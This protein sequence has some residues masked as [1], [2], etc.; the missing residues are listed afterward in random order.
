MLDWIEHCTDIGWWTLRLPTL[1]WTWSDGMYRL[2]GAEPGP[3]DLRPGAEAILERVVPTDRERVS[4]A[5]SV[6]DEA[7]NG[8]GE[9][10]GLEYWVPSGRAAPRRVRLCGGIEAVPDTDGVSWVGCAQDVTDAY[11]AARAFSPR[12]GRRRARALALVR[13]ELGAP[14]PE[15]RARS[16]F[17]TGRGMDPRRERPARGAGQVERRR[18]DPGCEPN[19]A[20]VGGRRAA[21]TSRPDGVGR[22][23]G[24]CHRR[25]LRR[26]CDLAR[27]YRRGV[28]LRVEGSSVSRRGAR[29]CASMARVG[30]RPPT[31]RRPTGG[32]GNQALGSRAR[33]PSACGR[34]LRRAGHRPAPVRQP[35]DGE[36][37]LIH[38]YEKLGVND[39]SA[40]VARALRQGLIA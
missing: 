34:W 33:G 20:W 36:D 17:T 32:R 38:V 8:H 31:D 28:H 6:L 30:A 24:S 39:R 9:E 12:G 11:L 21:Q 2:H 18:R 15:P 3:H 35:R 26:P 27:E 40:A 16:G 25:R 19:L 1:A 10:I 29:G 7:E 5:L 23:R 13:A 22:Q 4:S 14:R 37:A